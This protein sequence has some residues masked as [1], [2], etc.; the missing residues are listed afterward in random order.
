[1]R[2]IFRRLAMFCA[3]AI[4]STAFAQQAHRPPAVPLAV[5][6]PY[7]SL[8]SMSDKLTDSQT[9]VWTEVPQSLIGLV[10]IDDNTFRWMGLLLV[11]AIR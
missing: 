8:W 4:V 1:M 11:A 7:F 3:V 5:N 2:Y 6:D 9:K 10:R